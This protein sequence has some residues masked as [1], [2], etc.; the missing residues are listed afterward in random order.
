MPGRLTNRA[1]LA[2]ARAAGPQPAAFYALA[3]DSGARKGE[4]CGRVANVDLAAG[5]MNRPAARDARPVAGIRPTEKWQ[6]RT[7]SLKWRKTIAL[8]RPTNATRRGSRWRTG[9]MDVD[10]GLSSRR[11]GPTC[12][13]V[14]TAS[15]T[16]CR[17]TTRTTGSTSTC[18]R[19]AGV[20]SIKSPRVSGI[21]APSSS[22]RPANP[23]VVSERLVQTD[24]MHVTDACAHVL[25][26]KRSKGRLVASG[27]ALRLLSGSSGRWTNGGQLEAGGFLKVLWRGA[28]AGI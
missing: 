23:C 11:N 8:L 13:S 20:R 21:P 1:F 28:E 18:S 16:Y 19:A 5:K 12:G 27:V 10:H 6:P 4:L 2:A 3:L 9:P 14:L 15:V 22:S 26:D 25:P 24:G 17:S 7:V